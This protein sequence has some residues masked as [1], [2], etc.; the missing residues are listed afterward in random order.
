MILIEKITACCFLG[1]GF[2]LCL[3]QNLTVAKNATT[4]NDWLDFN[5]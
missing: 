1:G 5:H 4:Q 3:R 2:I